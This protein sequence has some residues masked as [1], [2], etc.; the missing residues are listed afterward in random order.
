MPDNTN[1]HFRIL[2]ALYQLYK[3]NQDNPHVRELI[4]KVAWALEMDLGFDNFAYFELAELTM[5]PSHA[6]EAANRHYVATIEA[7]LLAFAQEE[8]KIVTEVRKNYEAEKASFPEVMLQAYYYLKRGRQTVKST[9]VQ[10]YLKDNQCIVK[11]GVKVIEKALQ[12][13]VSAA[14]QKLKAGQ[15]SVLESIAEQLPK[16]V[17]S[18]ELE[19]WSIIKKSEVFSTDPWF[20]PR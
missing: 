19:E 6:D 11:T 10:I 13:V 3:D 18:Y 4:G 5:Q 20:V 9:S 7:Q 17:G 16:K 8:S 2:S 12:S 14:P 15:K 1:P